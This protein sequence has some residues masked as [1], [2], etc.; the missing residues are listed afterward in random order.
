MEPGEDWNAAE[1]AVTVDSY[2]RMLRSGL[3]GEPYVKSHEN[4]KVQAATNRSPGAVERK[5]MNISAVLIGLG[6]QPI[7]GYKPL[8]NAQGA[9]REAVTAYWHNNPDVEALMRMA[10]IEPPG[11]AD[12]HWQMVEA[13]AFKLD[14]TT[15]T[16][17]TR[18]P[19]KPDF[20][21]LEAENRRL[22][23]AGESV[24]VEVERER[25]RRLGRVRLAAKVEHV[26]AT[27]GAGSATTFFRSR[28][29]ARKG[30]SK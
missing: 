29:R 20:V 27:Q 19:V 23:L 8:A 1:L 12:L 10:A 17:R 11:A 28:S 6:A 7:R 2:F 21:Q 14:E 22:G 26:S 3:R 30:S 24:V 16:P 5:H 18:N 13:P 4:R 9:L 25:L 15:S